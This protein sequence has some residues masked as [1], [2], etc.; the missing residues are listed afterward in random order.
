MQIDLLGFALQIVAEPVGDVIDEQRC[1]AGIKSPS[2]L[3]RDSERLKVRCSAQRRLMSRQ[4]LAQLAQLHRAIGPLVTVS[5]AHAT[6]HEHRPIAGGFHGQPFF[7]PPGALEIG[8][9]STNLKEVIDHLG[10]RPAGAE[11]E[12]GSCPAGAA[13]F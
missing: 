1:A 6:V 5:S 11:V 4:I 2:V 9:V 8:A 7:A 13:T 10:E 3:H 12:R